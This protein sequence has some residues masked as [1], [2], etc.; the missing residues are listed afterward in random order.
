MTLRE[1]IPLRSGKG[2]PIAVKKTQLT[3]SPIS[4][5]KLLTFENTSFDIVAGALQSAFGAFPIRLT[6]E[7]H[8]P[9]LQ[10]M[11]HLAKANGDADS[12]F[13]QMIN[14]LARFG[15]LEINEK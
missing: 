3:M 1:S 9:A 5:P 4:E 11:A 6:R 13:K 15:Q 2:P 8:L 10:A 12:P 7:D 14:Y